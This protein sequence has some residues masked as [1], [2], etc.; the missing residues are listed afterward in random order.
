MKKYVKPDLY[1]ESFQLNQHIAAC[2]Y[3]LVNNNDI[4]HCFSEGDL[5]GVYPNLSGV[6]TFFAGENA[7]CETAP[8]H[9]CYLTAVEDGLIDEAFKVLVS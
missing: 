8:E 7:R 3:D 6:T 9:Y 5:H 1:F 4:D 2:A